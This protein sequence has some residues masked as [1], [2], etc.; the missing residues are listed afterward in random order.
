MK[1]TAIRI[2]IIG[3]GSATF[4]AGIVRDIC[5]NQGLEG[6][7][8]VFMDID[9]KRLNAIHA[10]GQK[11]ARELDKKLTFSTTM[12]RREAIKG[13]DFIINTVQVKA[14]ELDGHDWAEHQ[15][16]L[17]ERHGYYRGAR[18]YNVANMIFMLEVANDIKEL[19]PKAWLLQSGNPVHEGCT[20]MHRM[21]GINVIGL[22]HGHYGYKDIARVLGIGP[23]GIT[24]QMPGF[25]H[26]I[27]MTDFRHNGR[28]VYPL[29]D[30]W[31]ETKAEEYW[32][33]GGRR[34]SDM[35]MSRGAIHQYKL[36]GL[37]P[38]GDT[39]RVLGWWYHNDLDTKKKWFGELGGFDSEI[40]WG[41]YLKDIDASV[42]RVENAA[43]DDSVRATDIFKPEQSGEQIVPIIN[44]MV[45]DEEALY[46]VNIPNRGHLLSDFPENVVVET[47]GVVN[48]AGVHGVKMAPLPRSIVAG[49]MIQRWR[50]S[51]ILVECI[52]QRDLN[53][54]MLNVLN[55]HRT[56]TFDQADALLKEW[57][58]LRQNTRVR[59]YFKV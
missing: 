1:K 41:L 24:A 14:E 7:H 39:P 45:N 9:E 6:S 40:G 34:Y 19:N 13:A 22:C 25:N 43:Y 55:D 29:I 37:M 8:V 23:E 51:E 57:L 56:R 38:I 46:Q 47:Q 48:G 3:A 10:L 2:A 58:S 53:L 33:K 32:A 17:G 54:L 30:E 21:T 59:D 11:I 31:I 16:S 49:A 35:Q 15:R 50:D 28:D 27:F 12:D 5:I 44:S 4:S 18:L 52:A 20:V 26:F 42:A 36:Y